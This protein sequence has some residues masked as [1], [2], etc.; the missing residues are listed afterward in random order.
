MPLH[1]Q[2]ARSIRLMKFRSL[3][4]VAAALCVSSA[5]LADDH[6]DGSNKHADTPINA[7]L[8]GQFRRLSNDQWLGGIARDQRSAGVI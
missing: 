4:I 8:L 7:G 2:Y 1:L 3:V 5:V 6:A